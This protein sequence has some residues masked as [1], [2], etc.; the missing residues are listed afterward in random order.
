LEY[1]NTYTFFS[2][3]LLLLLPLL[4][5]SF[6]KEVAEFLRKFFNRA[7]GKLVFKAFVTYNILE[8]ITKITKEGKNV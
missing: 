2:F 6:S 8:K 3:F 1:Q 4:V 7:I 5:K